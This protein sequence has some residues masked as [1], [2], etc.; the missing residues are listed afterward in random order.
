M[1]KQT[2]AF[3]LPTTSGLFGPTCTNGYVELAALA[4]LETG[5]SAAVGIVIREGSSTGIVLLTLGLGISGSG[6]VSL[7]N[8]VKANTRLYCQLIGAGVLD[9]TA[10]IV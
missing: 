7:N 2:R 9:G 1:A 3:K 8:P 5:G 10:H 4:A 6:T